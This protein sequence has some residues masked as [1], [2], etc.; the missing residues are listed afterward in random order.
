MS[1]IVFFNGGSIVPYL[2]FPFGIRAAKLSSVSFV[3]SLCRCS[4]FWVLECIC[5]WNLM[6]VDALKM[7]SAPVPLGRDEGNGLGVTTLAGASVGM[8]LC[9]AAQLTPCVGCLL[10]L[11]QEAR[12][13]EKGVHSV[14][15]GSFTTQCYSWR[16]KPSTTATLRSGPRLPDRVRRRESG[17]TR[18]NSPCRSVAD[19]GRTT[20]RVCSDHSLGVF[21]MGS[22]LLKH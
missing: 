10:K 15:I 13:F 11:Q 22:P 20:P 18:H 4:F 5:F 12:P 14:W 7:G 17:V 9:C 19:R 16:A 3:G 21:W 8:A 1:T 2:M 6:L